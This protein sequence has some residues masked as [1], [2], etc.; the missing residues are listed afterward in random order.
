MA[1]AFLLPYL[2]GGFS[3]WE[4]VPARERLTRAQVGSVLHEVFTDP[5]LDAL[6]RREKL[7][8]RL[9]VKEI[10]AHLE[11]IEPLD[12]R[13]DYSWDIESRN[14]WKWK[15][16]AYRKLAQALSSDLQARLLIAELHF[17]R[18]DTRLAAPLLRSITELSEAGPSQR[19]RAQWLLGQCYIRDERWPEGVTVQQL[20]ENQGRQFFSDRWGTRVVFRVLLPFLMRTGILPWLQRK[21]TRLLTDGVVPVRLGV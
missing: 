9:T 19:S 10:K 18:G 13:D 20:Q 21:E 1:M 8:A 16:D 2:R 14:T 4:T 7:S 15:A 6:I 12:S 5:N 11:V 3:R 17:E